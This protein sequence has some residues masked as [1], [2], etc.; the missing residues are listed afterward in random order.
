[1]NDQ[2]QKIYKENLFKGEE[3][4]ISFIEIVS[5]IVILFFMLIRNRTTVTSHIFKNPDVT[6]SRFVTHS[7]ILNYSK[8]KFLISIN[9]AQTTFILNFEFEICF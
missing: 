4:P 7:R 9:I 8:I 6:H 5:Y 1:M 2:N 3:V